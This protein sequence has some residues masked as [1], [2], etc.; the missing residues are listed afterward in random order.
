MDGKTLIYIGGFV[1]IFFGVINLFI[2]LSRTRVGRHDLRSVAGPFEMKL[3][4]PAS[5]V[6]LVAFGVL[7][8]LAALYKS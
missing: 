6:M 3:S 7:L 1:L 8:L 2:S 4:A 5:G